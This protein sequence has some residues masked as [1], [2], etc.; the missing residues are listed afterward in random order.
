MNNSKNFSDWVLCDAPENYDD[1]R[2]PLVYEDEDGDRA[3]FILSDE[4]K[5]SER[6][7]GRLTIYRGR[8]SGEIVGG[9]IKCVRQLRQRLLNEF[10]GFAFLLRE[11]KIELAI[12]F[13]AAMFK[14]K[15]EVLTMHYK[16]VYDKLRLYDV[17]A[18]LFITSDLKPSGEHEAS[19]D[20]ALC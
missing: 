5:I 16:N 18:G 19:N 15:D 3:E 9:S 13:A 10:A 11:G 14:Q 8:E 6:V 20:E 1:R 4:D 7:D 12:V 2:F 17:K